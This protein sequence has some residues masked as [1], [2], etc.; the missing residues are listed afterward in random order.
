MKRSVLLLVL[1]GVLLGR[2]ALALDGGGYGEVRLQEPVGEV[3]GFV[4]LFSD[5]DGWTA[6]DDAAKR[7]LAM[8]GVI[9]VG[10]DTAAYLRRL[11]QT[12]D[13]CHIIFNDA[14]SLSRQL[15]RRHGAGV[16]LLPILAGTGEGGT[17]AQVALSQAPP[18]TIA[19]AAALR[20]TTTVA[21]GRPL[22][23]DPPATVVAGGGF[24]YPRLDRLPGFLAIAPAAQQS[25]GSSSGTPAADALVALITPHL[26][27]EVPIAGDVSS[28]PLIELPAPQ[29]SNLMAIVLSGDGGWRDLDKT[30]AETLAQRGISVVGWD[31]VRYFWHHKTP[32]QTAADLAAVIAT[33]TTRFHARYVAL[34]GY[35][36]GADVLPFAFNRL[37]PEL[38]DRVAVVS[39]L[40][41]A[42][43]A[44]FEI[45]VTGWL[46]APVSAAA[47]PTLPE[48]ARMPA[49]LIQCFYGESEDDTACPA[50]V[51]R[52]I[53]IIRTPGGHHFGGDYAA[54]AARIEEG[55]RRRVRAHAA[56]D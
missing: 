32:T 16:Y 40:G 22:C 2:S 54:L 31:C 8:A 24:A 36:F 15:Q 56:A 49:V 34:V 35:S 29:P 26:G 30:L 48:T 1:C 17:V 38:R 47:L 3:R 45:S 9:V 4:V 50:L 21:G 33:Y 52:G 5:A 41:F 19:G 14:E 12:P 46:G 18:N 13:A 11:D 53:E 43:A 6:A 20:P 51:P 27:A 25:D 28:L 7:L 44:D 55:L 10:V 23:A 37:P 39:L 42:N